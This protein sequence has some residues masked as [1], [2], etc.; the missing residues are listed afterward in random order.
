MEGWVNGGREGCNLAWNLLQ[1]ELKYLMD[2]LAASFISA[3]DLIVIT[4]ITTTIVIIMIIIIITKT[5][6]KNEMG[7]VCWLLLL[8]DQYL[9]STHSLSRLSSTKAQ[10]S[11]DPV[12]IHPW[13]GQGCNSMQKTRDRHLVVHRRSFCLRIADVSGPNS[14]D[15]LSLENDYRCCLQSTLRVLDHAGSKTN[16]IPSI[17]RA[18][19]KS[20]L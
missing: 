1:T 14:S 8:A 10:L 20:L 6:S 9:P 17:P 11:M 15:Y 7:G 5:T 2:R 4:I 12:N 16:I 13:M 18:A 3:S 19:S